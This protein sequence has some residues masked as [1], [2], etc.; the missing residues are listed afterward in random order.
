ML[1]LLKASRLDTDQKLFGA[2]YA[3]VQPH[4]G[5]Q[6]NM[7]VYFGLIEAGDTVMGMDLSHGRAFKPR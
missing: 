2:E 1:M 3:N 7:A 4:S 5:V 6:A